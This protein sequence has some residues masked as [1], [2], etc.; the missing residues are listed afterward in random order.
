M[1][2]DMN[3]TPRT[4]STSFAKV[5]FALRNVKNLRVGWSRAAADTVL[6]SADNRMI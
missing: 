5:P 1:R 6:T 4:R 2:A 3:S